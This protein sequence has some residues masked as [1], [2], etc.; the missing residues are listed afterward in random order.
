V[1]DGGFGRV[2]RPYVDWGWQ[3]Y[4]VGQ[5]IWTPYGWTWSSYEPWSWTF[6]YGRWGFSSLY[7]W[8][9]TP[10][11]VW[12]PAW[13]DWFWGDGY[14]G[15]VPLGPPGFA[16]APGYWSY[17]NTRDFCAP[18]VHT[19]FVNERRLP[20]YIVHHRD[21]GWGRNRPPDLRDIEVA[22]GHQ[23]VRET[24]RRPDSIAP[25]VQHRTGR[26]ERVRERVYDGRSERVIEHTGQP[27]APQRQPPRVVDDGG[28]R[29]GGERGG[30]GSGF[31]RERSLDGH[32][33]EILVP[34]R[35]L[36][37]RPPRVYA[38]PG[39]DGDVNPPP[40][41]RHGR[42]HDYDRPTG[43]GP[44]GGPADAW[45]PQQHVPAGIPPMDGG[46]RGGREIEVGHPG[47]TWGP[48]GGAPPHGAGAVPPTMSPGMPPGFGGGSGAP[49]SPMQPGGLGG[50]GA[51]QGFGG[52]HR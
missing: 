12:G 47:H 44:Y 2:W 13:V 32:G 8:V 36:D 39:A 48:G 14:V 37:R 7:G 16:P 29:R 42:P 24:D 30:D 41:L 34:E 49:P 26:G 50:G 15:W 6:H 3:P 40:P 51:P 52:G 31:V 20:S 25:W 38:T 28:W 10:G 4:S 22:S 33:P 18:R 27:R 9:W 19:L 5:W 17:V 11:Y 1:D 46:R 35:R 23:L 45:P 43:R 21:Q